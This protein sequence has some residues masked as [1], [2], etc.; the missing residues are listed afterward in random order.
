VI[1]IVDVHAT[2]P[3]IVG[4]ARHLLHHALPPG[5]TDDRFDHRWEE[6]LAEPGSTFWGALAVEGGHPVGMLAGSIHGTR[7]Q[8]DALVEAHVELSQEEVL[9]RLVDRVQE[10]TNTVAVKTVEIWGKPAADWHEAVVMAR[11][12]EPHRSLHQMRCPL[13]IDEAALD[14]RAFEPGVDDEALRLVNNAAFLGH[15]DQGDLSPADFAEKLCEPGVSPEGIRIH[16]I[17]GRI[18]GFCW[19]KIHD[20][21]QLGEIFA[22]GLHPDFHGKGLG[23]PMTAAGLHWLHEQGLP[24][25]ML[26]VEAD[27]EPAIRTYRNLG[28]TIVRTDRAW[29]CTA[30]E[31]AERAKRRSERV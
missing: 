25:G 31:A 5:L 1:E 17:D 12:F 14:T 11:G 4:A 24:V 16:E 18:A 30:A 6:S 22:I 19:T 13:P 7:L 28:F 2:H 23:A 3:L 27:N 26:Y 10:R 9:E 15:P 29:Q 21:P 20:E 8:L